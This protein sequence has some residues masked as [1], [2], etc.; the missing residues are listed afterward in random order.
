MKAREKLEK[1]KAY[2]KAL[3]ASLRRQGLLLTIEHAEQYLAYVEEHDAEYGCPH[4]H[5]PG[6][7]DGDP[8]RRMP[9]RVCVEPLGVLKQRTAECLA[10]L[11]GKLEVTPEVTLPSLD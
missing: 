6:K 7:T 1:T 4:H 5:L 3:E 9:W 8:P 10:E 2:Q 11:R